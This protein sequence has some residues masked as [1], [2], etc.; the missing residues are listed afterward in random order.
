MS[1]EKGH[2]AAKHKAEVA[3]KKAEAAK[4]LPNTVPDGTPAPYRAPSPHGTIESR[5]LN[6]LYAA[7]RL[8]C[9]PKDSDAAMEMAR[10]FPQV[11]FDHVRLHPN[12][13][14][15]MARGLV[16]DAEARAKA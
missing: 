14:E 4:P 11:F 15:S 13:P 9:D 2:E 8:Y 7:E 1:T 5:T 16:D 6:Y 12:L 10:L 3:E